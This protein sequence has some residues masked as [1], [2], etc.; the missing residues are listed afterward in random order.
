MDI[1]FS[2][3]LSVLAVRLGR[4]AMRFG[5]LPKPLY[6]LVLSVRN[7]LFSEDYEISV[8]IPFAMSMVLPPGQFHSSYKA[9]YEPKVTAQFSQHLREGMSVVDVGAFAGYYTLLSSRLVGQS[10]QVYSFEA[11]PHNFSY[12]CRNVEANNCTNVACVHKAIS[13]SVGVGTLIEADH[14]TNHRVGPVLIREDPHDRAISVDTTTLDSYFAQEGWPRIDLIKMDI[15]GGE[16]SA[17]EGMQ[18]L[19]RRNSSLLLIME[20][21][22]PSLEEQG[23]NGGEL[24]IVLS[25]L[26]FRTALLIDRGMITLALAAG[27]PRDRVPYNILVSKVG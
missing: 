26:G 16:K 17:L 23:W 10:G 5:L 15:E 27:L 11:H 2:D 14:P 3:Y 6:Q 20:V 1:R 25:E 18:E 21:S 4:R 22:F 24:E 7:R 8:P 13:N 9:G 12:L 19:S